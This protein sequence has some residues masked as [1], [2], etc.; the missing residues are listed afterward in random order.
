MS[1]TLTDDKDIL[2]KQYQLLVDVHKF[3]FDF[4][5]KFLIFHYAV[6]GGILSFYLSK[7]NVGVMRFAL[8]FPIFMSLIFAGFAFYS[9]ANIDPLVKEVHRVVGLLGLNDYPDPSFLKWM[10]LVV[11]CL[12]ALIF[13][14][15]IVVSVARPH[16]LIQP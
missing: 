15:L 14:S 10:L 7:P 11:G 9:A 3:Y 8:V 2:M 6:T 1:N 4:V 12:F 13:V 16:T 5:L